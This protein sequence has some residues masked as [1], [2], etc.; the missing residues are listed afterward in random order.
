MHTL[1]I[2][3]K[4]VI[5]NSLAFLRYSDAVH[6]AMVARDK[7][8]NAF[9]IDKDVNNKISQSTWEEYAKLSDSAFAEFEHIKLTA[10]KDYLK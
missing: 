9:W 10:Y 6:R 7:Q 8:L 5:M 1:S 3:L 2:N 4:G